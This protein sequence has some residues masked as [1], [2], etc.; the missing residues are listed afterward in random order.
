MLSVLMK[1]PFLSLTA[2]EEADLNETVGGEDVSVREQLHP[3]GY[4]H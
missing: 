4:I 1:L 2:M 3:T